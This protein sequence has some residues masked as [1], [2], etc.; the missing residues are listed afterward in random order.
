MG[1]KIEGCA[2]APG[3]PA[4]TKLCALPLHAGLPLSM[5]VY[6]IHSALT[7][8]VRKPPLLC[9]VIG[10][11]RI[12]KTLP[13]TSRAE[14]RTHSQRRLARQERK[15]RARR[16]P[17]PASHGRKIESAPPPLRPRRP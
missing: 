14:A 7:R 11:G 8:G 12:L 3:L 5:P 17:P 1:K 10:V 15:P 9:I 2:V 16:G 13:H 4:G 6:L